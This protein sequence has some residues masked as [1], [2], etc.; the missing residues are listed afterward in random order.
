M[1]LMI[2]HTFSRLRS[3][4]ITLDQHRIGK[5]VLAIV[6]LL[7]LFILMSIFGGL[8]D[9][10]RQLVSPQEFIPSQCR[11]IVL[12][13][14][15]NQDNR[16]LKT[17]RSASAYR[18]RYRQHKEDE[19]AKQLEEQHLICQNFSALLH[20]I[21]RDRSLRDQL[22]DLLQ[23][24][25]QSSEIKAELERT[26]GAYNTELFEVIAEQPDTQASSSLKRQV[27][28]QTQRLNNLSQQQTLAAEAL[29]AHVSIQQL[30]RALD[31]VI[32]A[33]RD[34]L[35]ED[36]RERNFWYPVKRLAMELLFLLPL[37][38]IFYLWNSKSLAANRPY[39]VLISSHLLVVAFIPV[40][41]KGFELVYDLLPKK[42]FQQAF[43]LL[44]SLNL[45]ALWHYLMMGA[46]VAGALA[47]IVIMQKKIFSPQKILQK[48]IAKGQCQACGDKLGSGDQACSGC[49][50]VQF[51]ACGAC[52]APTYVH[53][54]HCRACGVACG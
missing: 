47:L 37:I 28:T 44:E 29:Q 26:R 10:N 43:A 30:N 13:K 9:H 48:R 2:Q 1:A 11:D 41:F 36:L 38:L 51:K 24:R 7:D 35:L 40:L 33:D 21:E 20:N 39:Q 45:L 6:L 54:Q 16:L 53:G 42:F 32:Q 5:A 3:G 25:K 49:G 31:S 23:L 8:S 4:L 52:E 19:F 12:D 17:A 22:S 18:S 34:Q 46:A 27:K 15:W 14:K 50:F